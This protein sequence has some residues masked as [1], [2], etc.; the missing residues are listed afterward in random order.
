MRTAHCLAILILLLVRPSA[1]QPPLEAR[2]V[3]AVGNSSAR[4]SS[5]TLWIYSYSWYGLQQYKLADIRQGRAVMSL[6]VDRLKREVDPHPNTDAYVLVVQTGE[7]TWF[8][9]SDIPADGFWKDLPGAVRSLGSAAE[10]TGGETQ[11]ILPALARRHITLLDLEGHPKTDFEIDLS[12]YLWDRN[13]CAYHEG[14][15]LGRFRTDA[16][17]TVE[18]IAPLVPIYL[19]SLQYYLPIGTGPAGPAYSSDSGMKIPAEQ[20]TIVKAAWEV[21]RFTADL[22]VVTPEGEPRPHVDV[23]AS[24]GTNTCGGGDRIAETDASGTVQL[25]LDAT[26]TALTLIQ[27]GPY[28][29]SDP[30]RERNTRE[31]SDDELRELFRQQRLSIRW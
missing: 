30:D 1:A 19:D 4:V 9:S 29:A 27:G 21:P 2:F 15:A 8:R 18:V 12:V 3:I 22:T 11:L 6:D 7:H 5:G 14:L 16:K 23:F 31:V 28:S 13:H 26:I 20:N 24:W 17:G 10:L 25:S